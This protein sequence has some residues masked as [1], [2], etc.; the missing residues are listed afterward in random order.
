[1]SK[2]V[3]IKGREI[4]DSRGNPTVEVEVILDNDIASTAAVP[5]GASTGT[6]EAVELRDNDHNRYNGKGVLQAVQNISTTIR[7]ALL[8][9]DPEKQSAIDTL[10][11]EIDGTENK[12]KLGANAMLGVS[13]AVARA[14]AQDVALPLYRY[15]SA[16]DRQVLPMPFFNILNGGRHADNNVDIQEFM[17]APVGAPTFAEG[18][19]YAAET[20]QA[21]KSVCRQQKLNTGV[22]DE[23][24]FAP[25]LRS[26]QEALDL[27]VSGIE[28]AGYAPGDDIALALDAAASEFCDNV[29]Y[30]LAADN[31]TLD[32]EGMIAYYDTLLDRYPIVSIEDALSEHDWDGWKTLTDTLGKRVQLVGD[33]LFVTNPS[34]LREGIERGIANSILIKLN[35]IGTVTE[36]LQAVTTARDAGYSCMF[37]HRSGETEDTFLAD[38]AVATNAGQMKSGAPARSERV[39]KYNQI[40]RIEEKLGNAAQ[41]NRGLKW[42]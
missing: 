42:R 25:E 33:D 7:K 22:G 12:G 20:Y 21:L 29:S 8:G 1:M 15:L 39:S 23:G 5:S 28:K 35:Q 19:R 32:A 4:L 27:L 2:I 14:A 3:D 31:K 9:K 30:I 16:D 41:F 13:M 24:G 40:V 18:L 10:L 11:I 37:S 38:I 34:I 6:R 17:I 36:T 26:N